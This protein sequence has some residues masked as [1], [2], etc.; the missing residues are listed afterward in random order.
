LDLKKKCDAFEDAL[1]W[2][3]RK[4]NTYVQSKEKILHMAR[5]VLNVCGGYEYRID[6]EHYNLVEEFLEDNERLAESFKT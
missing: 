1:H 3:A 4:E 5:A 6:N 2:I